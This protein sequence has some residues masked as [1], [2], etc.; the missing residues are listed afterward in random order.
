MPLVNTTS[1]EMFDWLRLG[2]KKYKDFPVL[3]S[4]F[5]NCSPFSLSLKRTSLLQ[6]KLFVCLERAERGKR[7]AVGFII[8]HFFGHH[9]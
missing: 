5:S 7:F 4:T 8:G 6:V 9:H 2:G 3:H 1:H